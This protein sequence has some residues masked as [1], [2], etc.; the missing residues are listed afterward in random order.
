VGTT[1][2][3]AVEIEAQREVV[4]EG[5]VREVDVAAGEMAVDL[6]KQ[7]GGELV[8][9]PLAPDCEV[10]LN[11]ATILDGKPL[12]PADLRP[13]DLAKVT[14]DAQ[15]RRVEA[16]RPFGEVG[17]IEAVLADGLVIK[18]AAGKTTNFA[19]GKDT[20][21]TL[22]GD[23]AQLADLRAGDQ[24]EITH[25]M[26]GAARPE[27][28]QIAARR[29]SDSTRWAIVVGIGTYGDPRFAP[30]PVASHDATAVHE[31]LVKRHAVPAGQALLL[32]DPP[33]ARLAD[34]IRKLLSE[35]RPGHEVVVYYSGR[36]VRDKDGKVYLAARDSRRDDPAGTG[37][38][39]QQL[40]DQLEASP[41]KTKLLLLDAS[42]APP[43]PDPDQALSSA[44]MFESLQGPPGQA[45]LRTVT[46]M[47]SCSPGERGAISG[48]NGPGAF[49]AAVAEGYSGKAD[50]NRDNQIEPSELFAWLTE[51]MPSA[52]V[53]GRQTPQLFLPDN[54]PPRLAENAK[55]AIRALAGQVR[56]GEADTGA[57]KTL[58]SEAQNLAGSE[59]EP[60]LLYGLVLLKS[61]QSR[62]RAEAV[63]HFETLKAEKPDLLLPLEVFAWLRF[64]RR[65]YQAGIDD[66]TELVS[67]IP[68]PKK[69]KDALPA[70]LVYLF[71]W[72]GRLR[73]F[74]A[75]V[76]ERPVPEPSLAR[77][78]TAVAAHGAGA[79]KL[80]EQGREATRTI[81]RD[82]DA[83]AAAATDEATRAKLKI[84]RRQ[85]TA[86]AVF[87]FDEAVQAIL[88]GMDR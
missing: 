87:P 7:A 11:G 63:K 69:P 71:P 19:A 58:Y 53:A 83:K 51:R 75:M 66:L 72:V 65:L 54:R 64:E 27:A 33:L 82:F 10:V 62:L 46:G 42:H 85:V 3:T 68:R 78:D 4:I 43:E 16:Y 38:P 22:G 30:L 23:P 59:V 20:K 17:T 5:A 86:Y 21:I 79:V 32:A 55:K 36:A 77:L 2:R 29:P 81:A 41:A 52:G 61:K 13:G 34:A 76:D 24:V 56:A 47:A 88:V 12:K 80:Y 40:V 26:P 25:D 8:K 45:A 6:G 1:S 31:A 15:V 28:R 70:E 84:D 73:E 50:K 67:R 9:L 14:H 74:A 37:M 49:A 60:R 35:V 44:E 48:A 57:A 39:L 18:P